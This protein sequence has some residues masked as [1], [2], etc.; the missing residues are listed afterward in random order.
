MMR[1][2]TEESFEEMEDGDPEDGCMLIGGGVSGSGDDDKV[3][4]GD[5]FNIH[6]E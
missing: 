5:L 6:F 4:L 1:R 2:S 3:G